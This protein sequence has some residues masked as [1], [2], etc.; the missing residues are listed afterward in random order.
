MYLLIHLQIII[1]QLHV[2][3]NNIFEKTAILKEEKL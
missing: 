3:I 1:Q 2:D